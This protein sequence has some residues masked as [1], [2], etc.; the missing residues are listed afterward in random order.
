LRGGDRLR[1]IDV[2]KEIESNKFSPVYIFLGEER[3]LKQQIID[4]IKK[5]ILTNSFANDF[6][7]NRFYADD[8]DLN[9]VIEVCNTLPV[10]NEKRIVL[11]E[12][13]E[14]LKN[15][16]LLNDYLKLPSSFTILILNS[17]ERAVKRLNSEYKN[18]KKVVFY[19]LSEL[20]LRNWIQNYV[21]KIGKKITPQAVSVLLLL[22]NNSLS[23]LNNELE[24][25][26]LY[27]KDNEIITEEDVRNLIEDVKEYNIFQLIDSILSSQLLISLKIFKKMFYAGHNVYSIFAL[28][29]K[30]VHEIFEIKYML[31]VEKKSQQEVIQQLNINPYRFKNILPKIKNYDLRYLKRILSI[32]FKFDYK[33][34]STSIVNKERLF[35]DLIWEL[36][37][38]AS[39]ERIKK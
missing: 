10:F 20:E 9:K 3:Y 39:K 22:C 28:L 14:K 2:K 4:L 37:T 27:C 26:I 12:N 11:L 13:I 36:I 34:K 8:V 21:L 30:T 6:N 32:L 15:F 19:S 35:E 16:K 17:N 25:L 38:Y 33:F 7:F 29:N 5:R 23:E 24:K 31:Q 18:V 1:Y